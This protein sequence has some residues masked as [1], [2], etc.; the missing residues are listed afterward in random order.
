MRIY[1]VLS[2]MVLCAGEVPFTRIT[3]CD[4]QATASTNTLNFLTVCKSK[5]CILTAFLLFSMGYIRL[6]T[7]SSP[8]KHAPRT[9][10]EYF[11]KTASLLNI[12]QLF[13]DE[14]WETFD[15]VVIGD[16]L[17]I[18]KKSTESTDDNG[19]TTTYEDKAIKVMPSGFMGYLEA[20]ILRNLKHIFDNIDNLVK[21]NAYLDG[22]LWNNAVV[23]INV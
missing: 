7:K 18:I 21:I 15:S 23:N 19:I 4:V 8:K 17:K 9:W 2:F 16:Q 6:V 10:F 11:I 5:T 12:L 13:T 22:T 20:Y 3:A 14:Y 1:Y